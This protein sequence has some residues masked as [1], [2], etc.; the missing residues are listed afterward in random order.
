MMD[1]QFNNKLY[2]DISAA[3]PEILQ[4]KILPWDMNEFNNL[5]PFCKEM[6]WH[7]NA[8]INVFRV[9]GTQ[10]PDY[11]GLTWLD[12]LDKGKR[13]SLNLGLHE[14]NPGYYRD[15]SAKMPTMYYQSIDG[16]DIFIGGD[17]NH[18][19][20]IAK[21]AFFL[22]GETTL[23]GVSLSDY[24]ID[25]ALKNAFDTMVSNI[26]DKGIRCY[27]K[28][29]TKTVSRD[30]TGGWMLEKYE[31]MLSIFFPGI[32]PQILD[33]AGVNALLSKMAATDNTFMKVVDS[34]LN[35]HFR[36]K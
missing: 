25:W 23:H 31:P 4:R 14:T 27:V 16:G 10:H 33:V 26:N 2:R 24:R 12:F 13:M 17:G 7:Y 21:A 29:V 9:V 30:D 34:F 19:T 1:T 32:A 18:R 20:A 35:H 6:Y 15:T 11:I 28:P 3:S 22:T 8:S 5:R 36:K